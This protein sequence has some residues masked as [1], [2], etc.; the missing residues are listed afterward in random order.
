MITGITRVRNESL[1]IADTIRH[2]LEYCESIFLYDDCSTDNTAEIAETFERVTVIRG[3]EWKQDRRPEET[4]HRA[5]LM[6]QVK[7]EWALCFDA[8]ERLV[9]ELPDLTAA[10]YKFRLFDGYITKGRVEAYHDGKLANL[11]RMWGPEYRDILILFRVSRAQFVGDGNR[12]PVLH[13]NAQTADVK[14]KHYG[15]CVSVEQW[16]ETCEYYDSEGWPDRYRHKWRD[17]KGKAIHKV[18][19]FG[20]QLHSWR[21]LMENQQHWISL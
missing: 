18:S 21:E 16:N 17:R 15:K 13:G 11:P 2:Y 5:L 1:I 4:R 3:D 10:G 12:C 20:R 9:G 19:D 14:V 8:D 6:S 7:T